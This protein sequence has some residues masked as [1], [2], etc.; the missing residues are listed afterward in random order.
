ML[1]FLPGRT[2]E[3]VLK[4]IIEIKNKQS[5]LKIKE[6]KLIDE[7]ISI[8]QGENDAENN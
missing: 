7:L 3:D 4:E 8:K 5:L 2:D 6:N 1:T